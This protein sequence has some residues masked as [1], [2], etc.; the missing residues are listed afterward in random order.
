[1]L[2][3]KEENGMGCKNYPAKFISIQIQVDQTY[4]QRKG[5]QEDKNVK[6]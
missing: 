2:D 3:L 5:A 1:M 6:V 4:I